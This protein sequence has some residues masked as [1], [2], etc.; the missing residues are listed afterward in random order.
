MFRLCIGCVCD[1]FSMQKSDSLGVKSFEEIM[2]E[3][4]QKRAALVQTSSKDVEKTAVTKTKQM[5]A[6]AKNLKDVQKTKQ[7]YKFTPIVFDLDSE[8]T[9]KLNA[10][11]VSQQTERRSLISTVNAGSAAGQERKRLSVSK[12]AH[13]ISVTVTD[14]SVEPSVPLQS[15]LS[16]ETAA[17]VTENPSD[18]PARITPVIKRQS[19]S[20]ATPSDVNKKRRTSVDTRLHFAFLLIGCFISNKC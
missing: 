13:N 5:G 14:I 18:T 20:S 4:Q 11:N 19:S 12:A 16:A 10:G 3:K 7:Q 9:E 15:D 8:K 17:A 6:V 1:L 2:R